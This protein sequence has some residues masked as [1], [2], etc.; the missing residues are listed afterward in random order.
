MLERAR[1]RAVSAV[2]GI[3]L[4]EADAR[5]VP[6][7]P[8]RLTRRSWLACAFCLVADDAELTHVRAFLSS[9]YGVLHPGGQPVLTGLNAGRLLAA[10]HRGESAGQLDLL[11]LTLTETSVYELPGGGRVDEPL[12]AARKADA[13]AQMLRRLEVVTVSRRERLSLLRDRAKRGG[14]CDQLA[15]AVTLGAG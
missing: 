6:D 2:V 15:L 13:D 10:W 7:G 12:L 1:A 8:E 4:V 9:I 14:S 11:R 5:D 3:E